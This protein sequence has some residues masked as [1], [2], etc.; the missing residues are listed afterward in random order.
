[1]NAMVALNVSK[2]MTVPINRFLPKPYI[3]VNIYTL[4]KALRMVLAAND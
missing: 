3:L 2:P 4:E 1:V